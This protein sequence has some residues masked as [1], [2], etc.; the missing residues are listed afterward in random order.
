[1]L[2]QAI[3]AFAYVLC[4]SLSPL[5]VENGEQPKQKRLRSAQI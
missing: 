3:I 1:M 5:L 2:P 4:S